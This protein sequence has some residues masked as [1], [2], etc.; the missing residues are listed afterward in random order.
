MYWS[1]MHVIKYSVCF[2]VKVACLTRF[3]HYNEAFRILLSCSNSW[4][5]HH[6]MLAKEQLGTTDAQRCWHL[7]AWWSPFNT[8]LFLWCPAL[9][10]T[11]QSLQIWTLQQQHTRDQ[12]QSTT[13]FWLWE[14]GTE[15]FLEQDIHLT[16]KKIE[17]KKSL[18]EIWWM[19]N[20]SCTKNC[21]ITQIW[22]DHEIIN[23]V[24]H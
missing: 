10:L 17:Q 24:R 23:S 21:F 11:L 1:S 2:V 3:V 18:Q 4:V 13:F 12:G 5:C 14:M 16:N 8:S 20:I 7:E 19:I 22:K 9:W 15:A 6:G